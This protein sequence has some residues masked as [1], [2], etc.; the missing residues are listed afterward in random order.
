MT[1]EALLI[2]G[3]RPFIF[4]KLRMHPRNREKLIYAYDNA[5]FG[6]S[7]CWE[8]SN[9]KEQ[10]INTINT[11]SNIAIRYI[12]AGN[13]EK[14]YEYQ[15]YTEELWRLLKRTVDEI[16]TLNVVWQIEEKIQNNF[17]SFKY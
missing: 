1:T 4:N 11:T 13:D 3:K 2:N 9:L 7:A 14:F 5:M 10:L 8:L 15:E 6:I 12:E 16:N 17:W